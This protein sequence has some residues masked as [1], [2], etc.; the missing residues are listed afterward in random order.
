[1]KIHNAIERNLLFFAWLQLQNPIKIECKGAYHHAT[2]V[3]NTTQV[4]NIYEITT[5][6]H[7]FDDSQFFSSNE[8]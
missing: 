4:L 2:L 6:K 8:I 3:L 5:R 7:N 1:M